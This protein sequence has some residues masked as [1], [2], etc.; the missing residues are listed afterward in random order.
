M[1][2]V[3]VNE[4]HPILLLKLIKDS[5]AV[6]NILKNKLLHLKYQTK[7]YTFSICFKESMLL[8][9]YEIHLCRRERENVCAAP[10]REY[11]GKTIAR[12]SDRAGAHSSV[13]LCKEQL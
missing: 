11:S 6:I 7:F 12:A 2:D 5:M 9:E 1:K 13:V 3:R 4:L 10:S 8:L